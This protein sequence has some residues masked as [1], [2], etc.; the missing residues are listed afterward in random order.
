MLV[1]KYWCEYW[2]AV[3]TRSGLRW[4]SSCTTFVLRAIGRDLVRRQPFSSTVRRPWCVCV[5]VPIEDK[6][7]CARGGR[8]CWKVLMRILGSRRHKERVALTVIV[9]HGRLP[10]HNRTSTTSARWRKTRI[11]PTVVAL[12]VR[13]ATVVRGW[14]PG[15]NWLQDKPNI[16]ALEEAEADA[17]LKVL[18]WIL[19]SRRYKER[20]AL[21]SIVGDSFVLSREHH[22]CAAVVA[23]HA[24]TLLRAASAGTHTTAEEIKKHNKSRTM[25]LHGRRWRGRLLGPYCLFSASYIN[26]TGEFTGQR[27]GVLTFTLWCSYRHPVYHRPMNHHY[28]Q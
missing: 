19:D 6:Y 17:C 3:D 9:H 8:S 22:F 12:L 16:A 14:C 25:L 2:T 4:R 7:C 23:T 27:V 11:S 21:T 1:W 28:S 18:M 20:V 26:T 5:L 24:L 10:R 15:H 13:C